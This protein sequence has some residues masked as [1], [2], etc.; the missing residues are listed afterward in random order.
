M[1]HWMKANAASG[2]FINDLHRHPIAY[3]SIKWLTTIFSGSEL[4]KN[5]APLSVRRGFLKKEWEALL[6]AGEISGYRIQW[7]WAFRWLVIAKN[8]GIEDAG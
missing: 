6:H 4:V 5:D 1:I 8:I 2:F 7:K 3:H